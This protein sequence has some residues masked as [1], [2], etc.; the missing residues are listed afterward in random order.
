[1]VSIMPGM[2]ARAPERTDDEQR[3]VG[4]A[5]ALAGV[6]LE[7]RQGGLDLR[8]EALGV[9]VVGGVVVAD[10]CGDRE[11]GRHRQPDAGHLGEVGALA[12]EQLAHV[13]VAFAEVVDVLVCHQFLLGISTR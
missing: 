5:E 13:L 3:V 10:L 11:A 8:L 1:M 6:L 7:L 2:L 9:G 4:V 12:A